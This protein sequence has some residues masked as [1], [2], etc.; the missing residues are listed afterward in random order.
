MATLQNFSVVF[1]A[2]IRFAIFCAQEISWHILSSA[3]YQAA[4]AWIREKKFEIHS[5]EESRRAWNESEQEEQT[6]IT[7]R[8][9]GGFTIRLYI[10]ILPGVNNHY[11]CIKAEVSYYPL[12]E[13]SRE[14]VEK[15]RANFSYEDLHRIFR[16]QDFD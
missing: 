8:M 3:N 15:S 6:K 12:G 4:P 5:I 13:Y 9:E 11:M 10:S 16:P 1:P 14:G 7:V 2:R